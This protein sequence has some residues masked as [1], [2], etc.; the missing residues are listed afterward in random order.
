LVV[1]LFKRG[2]GGEDVVIGFIYI[3]DHPVLRSVGV[4]FAMFV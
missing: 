4:R 3:I 2:S 1:L